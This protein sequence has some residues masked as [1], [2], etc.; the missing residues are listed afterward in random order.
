LGSA[1]ASVALGHGIERDHVTRW[2]FGALPESI[3]LDR[4]GIKLRGWPALVDQ[5]DAVAIR[6]LDSQQSAAAAMRGGLRRLIML[7]LGADL[8]TLRRGL[9]DAAGGLGR[10]RLQYAK[11]PLPD[12]ILS[13]PTPLG[14]GIGELDATTPGGKAPG[15]AA[16]KL[17]KRSKKKG[18]GGGKAA[19]GAASG[20]EKAAAATDLADEL[21]ALILDLTFTQGQPPIRDQASFEQRLNAQKPRLFAV[22]QEVCGL[23]SSILGTYQAVR[24]RLD[25]I[26]QVQW[27][28]SVLDMR[29][30][31][32]S[33]VYRGF[34]VQIPFVHL[35]DYPRYLRALEQRAEKLP[36]A[37]TRDRDRM[38]EL[39]PLLER[40][41]ERVAAAANAERKDE[42]LD[43]IRWMLEELR[44]S[45]FAQQLGTAYPISVKRLERRWRELGL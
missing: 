33:L 37:A 29:A 11:A 27:V 43:E 20:A 35:Q 17:G 2:D 44:V 18:K 45:L 7:A 34:L 12:P 42:R 26:T 28:P 36:L 5:G 24:K 22:A 15:K 13:D 25:G 16:V 39:A 10:L 1:N 9:C 30:H 6:V 4:S 23:A 32:D 8:R 41:R 31:L 38:Q 3:D 40:W 19:A 21:L 14:Q